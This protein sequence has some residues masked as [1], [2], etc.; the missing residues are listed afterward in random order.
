MF[1]NIK[2]IN[3][4]NNQSEYYLPDVLPLMI[5]D[6]KNIAIYMTQDDNEIRGANTL[7]QLTELEKYYAQKI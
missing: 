2:K 3:Y 6:N 1:K 5:K 4:N 7:E